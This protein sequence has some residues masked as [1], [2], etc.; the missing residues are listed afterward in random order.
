MFRV[1]LKAL[2]ESNNLTQREF[3]EKFGISK[4]TVGMW[5]SGAREPKTLDE[6]QRIADYF[7][8][9]VD[10]LLGRDIEKPIPKD[11]DG[12]DETTK[13]FMDLV[14]RLTP[15]Q[16]QLLLAQLQAWTEQNQLRSPAAPQS[17]EETTPESDL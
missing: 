3:A 11:G 4:G 14:D 10:Y 13:C 5:E 12:L 6:L 1:R 8:V 16:Q 2:R 17:D 9:S 7:H 15:D